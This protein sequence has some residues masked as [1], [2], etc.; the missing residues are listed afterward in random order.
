MIIFPAI[1]LKDGACVRL[2]LGE[3]DQATIF[4]HDPGAQ[5]VE[6]QEQG[7]SWI[8]IV[9]LNGA[10]EGKPVNIDAVKAILRNISIP[11]QL[12][13]EVSVICKPFPNGSMLVFRE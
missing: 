9:D 3:M 2:R 11:V 1:D 7:F 13:G 8:H 6:F 4:S 10:F 12:G 5:A